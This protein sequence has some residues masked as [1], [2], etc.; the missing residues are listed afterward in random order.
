MTI[1]NAKFSIGQIISH[2][3]FHYR[4]VIIDV[5]PDFQ[6]SKEWYE[7]MAKSQPAKD[8]PWYHVLVDKE[9]YETYVAEQNLS[10]DNSQEPIKHPLIHVVFSEFHNGSYQHHKH[11]H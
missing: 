2:K 4:G 8:R 6:G 9:E 5:D 7:Q 11:S 3:L 10:A 1:I